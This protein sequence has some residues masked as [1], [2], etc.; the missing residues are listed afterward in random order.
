MATG[1]LI[2]GQSGTG[3]STSI[4]KLPPDETFIINVAGKPLPFKG[5]RSKY[6]IYDPLTKKGNMI[7]TDSPSEVLKFLRGV[8]SSRP[9]IKYIILDDCQYVSGNEYMR[10]SKET[11]FAKFTDVTANLFGILDSIKTLREDLYVFPMFHPEVDTDEM[12]NRMIKAKTIGKAFDKYITLEGM[13]SIVLYTAVKKT[14]HGLEYSFV[15]Q[16]TGSNTGKAPMGM[17][18]TLEIPN[19]LLGVVNAI[20]AY[21]LD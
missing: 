1:V 4:T 9:E 2:I 11:G 10:R 20:K 7:N 14:D 8:S 6:E 13:F 17:F 5:W 3:K 21:E 16:N 15:T 12:G 18:D 19:D